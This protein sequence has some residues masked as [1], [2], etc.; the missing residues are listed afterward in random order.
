MKSRT[1]RA[2]VLLRPAGAGADADAGVAADTARAAGA[3]V[4]PGA[5]TDAGAADAI[6]DTGR[7]EA[8]A[9]DSGA[10]AG[11][12]VDVSSGCVLDTSLGRVADTP[13][14]KRPTRH[15]RI[16]KSDSDCGVEQEVSPT[17]SNSTVVN[18]RSSAM[19][20]NM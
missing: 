8:G 5:D 1:L 12:G 7:A 13:I 4:R 10:G 15:C 18:H 14:H 11:G 16:H 2:S 20:L 6:A 3:D 9:A 19:T 17:L